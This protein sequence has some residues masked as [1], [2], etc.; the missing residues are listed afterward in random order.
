[1][2]IERDTLHDGELPVREYLLVLLR[3]WWIVAGV[4]VVTVAAAWLIV[5]LLPSAPAIYE[6]RTK[7][8]IT[9]PVSERLLGQ[10][11]SN[12]KIGGGLKSVPVPTLSLETLSTLATANDLLER[13]IS[14]LDLRD[15]ATGR[16]WPVEQLAGMMN[17]KVATAGQGA[18]QT[19]LPLLTMTVRG[20]DPVPLGRITSKW[21]ELF[22]QKNSRLFTS[23]AARSYDFILA[24]YTEAQVSLRKLREQRVVFLAETRLPVLKS[25]LEFKGADLKQYQRTL[26]T[27]ST[28]QTLKSQEYVEVT[29][30]LN[31]LSVEGRWIGLPQSGDGNPGVVARTLEQASALQTKQQF[32]ATQERIQ[33]F[34]RTAGLTQ[35]KQRLSLKRDLLGTYISQL[36]EAENKTK[37]HSRTLDALLAEIKQQPQ[38]LVLVKAVADPV[39]WQILGP[40][41]TKDSW[42]RLRAL[43]LQTEE[44]NPTFTALTDRIIDIRTGLETERERVNLL[45]R[46]VEDTRNE[47]RSL[48][49]ELSDKDEIQLPRLQNELALAK[50]A[51]EKEQTLYAALKIQAA[52]LRTAVRNATAQQNEYQKLVDTYRTDVNALTRFV[53]SAEHQVLEVDRS[54][55]ILETT[56]GTLSPRLQEARIAKEE[57]AGSIRVVEAAVEPQ[58]PLPANP[59]RSLRFLA[60]LLG[61]FLGVVLVFLVHY[62]QVPSAPRQE[63][64]PPQPGPPES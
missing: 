51:Y 16:P 39:L 29:A 19:S 61:L 43:G 46:R 2:S 62:L 13:V 47:A 10:Q 23:E 49:Q 4:V 9:A 56:L 54:S 50:A 63:L 37:T 12:A 42:D 33:Q 45:T 34:Q 58:V 27:L 1:L 44:V 35:L 20:Q 25:E 59:R 3:R 5:R 26:L 15:P 38:F 11:D 28:E 24:L 8:L 22:V 32:F 17:A 48:E 55:S 14:E 41:P 7:L 21:S 18:A 60:P 64:H 52:D 6:A 31:D 30:R 53:T 36:E 40:N 57:Q